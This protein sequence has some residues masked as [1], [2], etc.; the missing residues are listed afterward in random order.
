MATKRT[1]ARTSDEL[2]AE[3]FAKFKHL[4]EVR[5]NKALKAM[6]QI[7]NLANTKV[8]GSNATAANKIVL[9]LRAAVD[10]VE[11]KFEGVAVK[12]AGFAL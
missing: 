4:A 11:E 3:K 2:K 1:T 7:G 8:Y 5:T 9:A 12:T 6:S 10:E